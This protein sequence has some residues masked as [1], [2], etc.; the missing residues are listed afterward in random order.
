MKGARRHDVKPETKSSD[1]LENLFVF[2]S[3][4]VFKIKRSAKT[5]AVY[6][7]KTRLIVRRFGM[8]SSKG[9]DYDQIS[10]QFPA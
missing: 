6:S 5:G 7:F 9:K 8:D 1:L 2:T 4:S 3:R 10:V